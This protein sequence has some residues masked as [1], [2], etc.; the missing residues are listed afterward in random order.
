MSFLTLAFNTILYR[1]L[2]NALLLLYEYLPGQDFGVAIIV[3]TCIIRLALYPSTLKSIK[4]QKALQEIQPKIKEIQTKFKHKK[5]EQ[6]RAMMELYKKEKINPLSGCLPLFSGFIFPIF[7]NAT[8]FS[9][10]ELHAATCGSKSPSKIGFA[11]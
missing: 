11:S 10:D 6:G 5:E 3:L 7:G 4:S 1:P 8:P 2:F 9:F